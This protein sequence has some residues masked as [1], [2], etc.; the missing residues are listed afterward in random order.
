M[1][2]NYEL[3]FKAKNIKK[4]IIK[5]VKAYENLNETDCMLKFFE[6]LYIVWK[7]NEENFNCNLGVSYLANIYY[8]KNSNSNF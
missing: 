6:K 7:F 5:G 8:E 4:S 1:I 2:G 3:I